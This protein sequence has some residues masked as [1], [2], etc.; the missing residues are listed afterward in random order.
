MHVPFYLAF[1]VKVKQLHQ[2]QKLLFS[3]VN[4]SSKLSLCKAYWGRHT[5]RDAE[6]LLNC[7]T[8]NLKIS[9]P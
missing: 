8:G 2:K 1:Y 5:E 4:I 3:T 7:H 6:H 9:S